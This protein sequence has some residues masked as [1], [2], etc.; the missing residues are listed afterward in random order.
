MATIFPSLRPS[1]FFVFSLATAPPH[2]QEKHI[3][4]FS[5]PRTINQVGWAAESWSRGKYLRSELQRL[6]LT[7]FEKKVIRQ[8]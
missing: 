2:L 1:V 5:F 6:A 4:I 3:L 8:I 7:Q